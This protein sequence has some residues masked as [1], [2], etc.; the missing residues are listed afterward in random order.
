MAQD[1]FASILRSTL[2][3]RRLTGSESKAL[4]QFL[5]EQAA[6]EEKSSYYRHQAFDI[7]AR[8]MRLREDRD[9]IEWLEAV[10]KRLAKWTQPPTARAGAVHE[11]R[12]SSIHDCPARI[13]QLIDGCRSSLD[14]CVFTIT[15]DR[16]SDRILAAHRRNVRVRIITDDD[17]ASDTGSD[18]PRFARSGVPVRVDRTPRH[19]HHKFALFDDE[20]LL[21]GSYNWTRGA[22]EE[23]LENFLVTDDV[24][25]VAAF[26]Q[27]FER[28]WRDLS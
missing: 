22:A 8:E 21:T 9:I 17:K 23:N 18:I 20:R 25:L 14:C 16:I 11:A 13:G 27:E 15:D 19:M 28:L 10:L 6:T 1:D 7:A 5:A 3:D 4:D 2:V 26:R 12:F 24:R